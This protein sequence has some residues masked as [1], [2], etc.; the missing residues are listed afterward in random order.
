[1][2]FREMCT[3]DPIYWSEGALPSAMDLVLSTY[4]EPAILLIDTW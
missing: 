3:D 4:V 2:R 1:V